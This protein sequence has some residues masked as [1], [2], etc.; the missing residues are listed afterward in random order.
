MWTSNK[1]LISTYIYMYVTCP[2]KPTSRPIFGVCLKCHRDTTDGFMSRRLVLIHRLLPNP[3]RS[4]GHGV[5]EVVPI[6]TC[7]TPKIL[8]HWGKPL[9]CGTPLSNATGS[10][11]LM[12]GRDL[13][14][15]EEN[16]KDW[17]PR[18]YVQ[19]MGNAYSKSQESAIALDFFRILGL[20]IH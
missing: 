13:Y 3:T 20:N 18:N 1:R 14:G 17:S 8:L 7:R 4:R 19:P 9:D 5:D 11:I 15:Q 12:N 6:V 16:K 2:L 10:G